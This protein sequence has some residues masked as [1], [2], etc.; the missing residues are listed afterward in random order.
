MRLID[1]MRPPR[2]V[3]FDVHLGSLVLHVQAVQNLQ[4][5]ARAAALRHWEQVE[6][7]ASRHST[8]KSSLVPIPVGGDAPPLVRAMGAASAAAGVGAIVSLPGALAEALARDL[9]RLSRLVVV[10]AE[11]DTFAI[12][13]RPRV[14]VVDPREGGAGIAVAVRSQRPYAFYCTSGRVRVKPAIG[15][16]RAVAVLADHG[17]VADAAASAMG[18]AIHRPSQVAR[19]LELASRL[20]GVRGVVVLAEGRI[21]V[22]GS[23]EI[24]SPA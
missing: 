2:L 3:P 21:G 4:D 6:A 15:R 20:P 14:F 8:F 17:A 10:S 12:D 5:E 19:A 11:G 23:I 18:Q 9:A 13:A 22:W 1:R 16:A 24:V 7:Y